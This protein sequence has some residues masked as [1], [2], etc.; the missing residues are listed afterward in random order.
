[1]SPKAFS[2]ECP[3]YYGQSEGWARV[4]GWQGGIS[5]CKRF[6]FRRPPRFYDYLR[7]AWL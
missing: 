5:N 4:K 2:V 7:L 6:A 1:M 3:I